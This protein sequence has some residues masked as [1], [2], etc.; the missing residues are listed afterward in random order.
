M[1]TVQE[2]CR[3]CKLY[4]HDYNKALSAFEY[5]ITVRELIHRYKYYGEYSLSRTFAFFM[6]ELLEKSGWEI[7]YIIPVPL[8][9]NRLKSRGFNQAALLGDYISYRHKIPCL[10]NILVRTVDT[11]SQTGFN[12]E[13]RALNLMN[14]FMVVRPDAVKGRN[15]LLIDDVYTTGAT[16]DSCSRELHKSGAENVY[17][18]T[19]AIAVLT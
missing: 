7:D 13:K 5:S 9:K 11:K 1:E 2:L 12:R 14:A 4:G 10:D 18:L 17:V 16:V 19:F 15:I 3:D 6:S 8:H